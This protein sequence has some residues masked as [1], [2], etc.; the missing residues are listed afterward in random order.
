MIKKKII[1]VYNEFFFLYQQTK[2]IL[3]YFT[4]KMWVIH[5]FDFDSLLINGEIYNLWVW[6]MQ[7]TFPQS[8]GGI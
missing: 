3:F 4:L 7:S 1:K 5:V 8:T 2:W 6:M